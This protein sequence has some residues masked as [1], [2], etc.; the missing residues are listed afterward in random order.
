MKPGNWRCGKRQT[1]S[2][3]V[4]MAACDTFTGV[5]LPMEP[6]GHTSRAILART[7]LF[8]RYPRRAVLVEDGE[9]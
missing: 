9:P 1:D 4:F 3:M 6:G 8:P 2:L 5:M 7:V